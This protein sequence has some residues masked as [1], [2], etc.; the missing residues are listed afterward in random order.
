MRPRGIAKR[1]HRTLRNR[2]PK[3]TLSK[4]LH[5]HAYARWMCAT[6]RARG[7]TRPGGAKPPFEITQ[8]RRIGKV[9]PQDL[10]I[11]FTSFLACLLWSLEFGILLAIGV[12]AILML[13]KSSAQKMMRLKRN[14]TL[15]VWREDL[16]YDTSGLPSRWGP[17]FVKDLNDNVLVIKC[18]G[19]FDFAMTN[20]FRDRMTTI[21]HYFQV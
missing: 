16:K 3:H 1:T 2:E 17:E 13:Y 19:F 18:M 15:G 6:E 4:V 12:S 11:W 9:Q 8:V 14:D 20:S 7:S 21:S 10:L 5:P